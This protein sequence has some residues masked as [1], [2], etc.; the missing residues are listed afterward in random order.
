MKHILATAAILL[1][2]GWSTLAVPPVDRG[3][4]KDPGQAVLSSLQLLEKELV[5]KCKDSKLKATWSEYKA[6][7]DANSGI[8]DYATVT[9]YQDDFSDGTLVV[10]RPVCLYLAED[11]ELA[12][13]KENDYLPRPG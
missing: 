8:L 4:L 3:F 2:L 1:C 11:V 10:K 9:L 13:N 7:Q 12:P 6:A 5:K